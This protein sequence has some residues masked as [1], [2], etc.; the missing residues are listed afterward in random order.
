MAEVGFRDGA[1]MVEV[2][3][4]SGSMKMMALWWT[5]QGCHFCTKS[6]QSVN[7]VCKYGR[8]NALQAAGL[9]DSNKLPHQQ[10]QIEAG[11]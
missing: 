2:A 10:S 8:K 5:P 6:G 4:S 11:Q 1:G 3:I 7:E 9:P